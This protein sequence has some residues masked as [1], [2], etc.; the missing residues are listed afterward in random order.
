MEIVLSN[1]TVVP[2]THV[3]LPDG[4]MVREFVLPSGTAVVRVRSVPPM[5][6]ADVMAANPDLVDPPIPLVKVGGVTEKWLPAR[7][8]QPEYE[9][10]VK[11]R[12]MVEALRSQKQGDY[13][14]DY[15]VVEWRR[16]VDTGKFS[17]TPPR[18]WKFPAWL[19]SQGLTPRSGVEGRRVDFIRYTLIQ[20]T[21]DMEATQIVIYAIT[22]P[23]REEETS[24]IADLFQGDESGGGDTATT[25]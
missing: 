5:M 13:A 22:N 6:I 19:K 17:K 25:G 14:W 2:S 18:G 1:G 7:A 8:G 21:S 10:W 3:E 12:G 16:P 9:E 15:G 11:E 24:A 4:S 23:L 20:T